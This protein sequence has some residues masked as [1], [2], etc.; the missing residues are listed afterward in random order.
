MGKK[1]YN[2]DGYLVGVY[3]D[4]FHKANTSVMHGW[5]E[6]FYIEHTDGL[7]VEVENATGFYN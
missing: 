3:D 5:M 7:W 6:G 4:D 2:D 1:I